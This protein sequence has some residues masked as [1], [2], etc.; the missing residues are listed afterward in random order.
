MGRVGQLTTEVSVDH[1]DF[2]I[3]RLSGELDM[4]S[5]EQAAMVLE[6]ATRHMGPGELTIDLSDLTFIDAS[7]VTALVRT[8][9]WAQAAGVRIELRGIHGLV[10]RVLGL[11]GVTDVVGTIATGTEQATVERPGTSGRTP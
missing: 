9:N 3:V 6:S 7:G 8:H 1:R 4:A 11:C 5:Y 10:A 2:P